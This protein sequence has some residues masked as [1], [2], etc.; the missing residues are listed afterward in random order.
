MADMLTL[1]NA[2]TGLSAAGKLIQG[3][4][5]YGAGQKSQQIL[6]AEAQQ[7]SNVGVQ[8]E[9]QLRASAR[10]AIGDQVA[11]QFSNGFLGGT[12]S[13]LDL[14]HQSQVNAAADVLNLRSQWTSK[15]AAQRAQGDLDAETGRNALIGSLFSAGGTVAKQTEDWTSARSGLVSSPAPVAAPSN[16]GIIVSGGASAPW[17]FG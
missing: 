1:S 6:D 8:Q 3:I 12:G 7:T 16:S 13:A 11:G 5:S 14:L 4:G 15:A 17:A 10:Q 9:L 2:S